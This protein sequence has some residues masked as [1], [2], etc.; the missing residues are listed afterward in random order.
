[1]STIRQV[2]IKHYIAQPIHFVSGLLDTGAQGSNFTSRKLDNQLPP[3]AT[4]LSKFID[5]VV[6]LN[7]SSPLSVLLEIQPLTVSFQDN[8]GYSHAH[9]VWYSVLDVLSHEIIIGLI[10]LIGPYYDL[11]ED[12]ITSYDTWQQLTKWVVILLL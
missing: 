6:R 9:N 12:S 4:A 3:A 2:W 1:M 11:F 8:N 10:D 7:D 5:R